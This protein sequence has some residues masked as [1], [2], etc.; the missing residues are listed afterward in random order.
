M[1]T[2]TY[3]ST[4]ET[5]DNLPQPDSCSCIEVTTSPSRP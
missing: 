1:W 2:F 5:C 4:L 3:R